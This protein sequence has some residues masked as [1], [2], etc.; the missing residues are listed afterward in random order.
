MCIMGLGFPY[1][2]AYLPGSKN[3]TVVFLSSLPVYA[4]A[5]ELESE[6]VAM[7]SA[8]HLSTLVTLLLPLPL[9]GLPLQM[10]HCKCNHTFILQTLP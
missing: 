9:V 6:F 10:L 8:D 5:D 3:N 4:T 1:D 2:V 7:L